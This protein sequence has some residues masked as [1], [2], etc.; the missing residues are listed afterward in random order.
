MAQSVPVET[1]E[2]LSVLAIVAALSVSVFLLRG[3]DGESRPL[4]TLRARFVLGVPWG[5]ALSVLGVLAVY[6]FLQ[7]GGQ[8]GGPVVVGFRS[9]S[10]GYPL[11]MVTA[12]F[13]HAGEAH[14][15]GN[16]L[17]TV[18]FAPVAEYAWSHYPTRRGSH[19]FG[20]WLTNPFVRI[21]LFVAGVVLVGL[22]TSIFTPGALIGFS[23]VVFAFGGFAV[24]TRPLTA[25]YALVVERVV[26]VSY[27]AVQN[28]LVL[29]RGRTQFVTPGWADVA[30]Q[31]HALGLLI[32]VLAGLWLV[33]SRG[34]W[35]GY[36]RVYFATLVFAVAKS[37]YAFYWYL[38]NTEYVLFR[39]LGIA[40][41][42]VL[43]G[44]VAVALASR[45]RTL[46]S[47]IDLSRREVAV[48]LL[49][50]VVLAIGIV[51]VPYNL[52]SVGSGPEADAGV[53]VR[54]YTVT[55]AEQVPNQYI[56]GVDV[57]YLRDSLTVNTSG[58]IVTSEQRHAWE[59]V[60]PA[61][62]L[63]TRGSV[64]V[65]VGGVGWRETVVVSRSGW[66]VVDGEK[67][68]KVFVEPPD[69]TATQVFEADPV[70]VPAVLNGKRVTLAPAEE[71]YE[72]AVSRNDTTVAT[73]QVPEVDTK[74][75]IGGI[76]FSRN[77]RD[78]NASVGETKIRIAT[79]QR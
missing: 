6:V 63:A 35:P 51:A 19:S 64:R 53:E 70:R 50:C 23:G 49:L 3:R 41:L 78:L 5:T 65:P 10:F 37:L 59:A 77:G 24:V 39:G 11:G 27:Y 14:V 31:G 68:Y 79:R 22:A 21:L 74:E 8:Q 71:G 43:A 60:V 15:T 13:A 32:G 36:R 26:S 2:G 46:V 7:G 18:V 72:L 4:D 69:R 57:P 73:G 62:R 9:W 44:V 16:L 29:A 25:V 48:G 45:D 67:T 38:S 61:G 28:P 17:G 55:Y 20:G 42:F 34:A 12:A 30:I 58:V 52:V 1:I 56:A 54:D 33:R 75:T 47:S 40:A 76:T 66:S